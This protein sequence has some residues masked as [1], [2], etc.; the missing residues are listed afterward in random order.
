MRLPRAKFEELAERAL[1]EIP[2]RFRTLLYNVEITVRRLPGREAGR[3][4]G[5]RNLLGLYS[6]LSREEMLRS[7]AGTYLPARVTLYQGNLEVG[8]T[9]EAELAHRVRLTLRH[10]LAHHFGFTDAELK[11]RWPEGA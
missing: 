7:D 3:W 2:E 8:C 5:S 11:E 1:A 9:D 4:A 6:G 10:E